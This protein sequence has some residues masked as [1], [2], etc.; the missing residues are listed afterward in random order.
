[1]DVSL[2]MREY[3][4]KLEEHSASFRYVYRLKND[5]GFHLF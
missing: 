2:E 5:L 4:F 3:K 1:M